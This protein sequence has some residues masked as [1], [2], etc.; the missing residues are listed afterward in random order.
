MG[1]FL[2]RAFVKR[3]IFVCILAIVGLTC[4]T[5]FDEVCAGLKIVVDVVSPFIV[6]LAIAYLLNIIMKQWERVWFPRSKK[7]AAALR[8][9]CCLLLTLATVALFVT[10]I[11]LLLSA[12]FKVVVETVKAGAKAAIQLVSSYTTDDLAAALSQLPVSIDI[13]AW[14]SSALK[15]VEDA[16]GQE[17]AA[18]VWDFGSNLAHG[19]LDVVIAII[20]ALYIL[21]DRE[22]FT[23]G[24]AS[25]AHTVLPQVWYERLAHF[26]TVAD[27]NFSR[28][29]VG[30]CL[31]ACILGVLCA[32]GMTILRLPF[33]GSIG[34]CVGVSS[35]IPF[36]GAWIGGIFG[37]LM[38]ASISV[39]QAIIFVVFLVVLQQIEGHLIYP[40]VVG[41][42]V[43]MPGIWTFV[44]V[45]AG[46]AL[47]GLLGV[48]LGVPVVSTVRELVL[49]WKAARDAQT[50][51]NAQVTPSA[52]D[53]PAEK[54]NAQVT[55]SAPGAPESNGE[56]VT[57]NADFGPEA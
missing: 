23:H 30:Q 8:R 55:H 20:F 53:N 34:L 39:K 10:I 7:T 48:L 6:G 42:T 2:D 52:S 24:V 11:V 17:I 38:I 37:A 44:A 27:K 25:A 51:K 14:K 12:D 35:L 5:R 26:V 19:V 16:N 54:T 31:E 29:V 28:F 1:G 46:A 49:E 13:D 18:K 45:I 4:V 50:A 56:G 32:L 47:M 3:S 41:N 33:A 21:I 36:L 15:A 9:P 40:N 57:S 43:G 22:R